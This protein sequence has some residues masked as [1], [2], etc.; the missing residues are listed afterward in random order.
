MGSAS[1]DGIVPF[2]SVTMLQRPGLVLDNN[3]PGHTGPVVFAAFGST[4]DAEPYHG[5]LVGWDARTLKQYSVFN[6]TPNGYGGSLWQSGGAPVVLPNGDI[7]ITSGNGAFDAQTT[8]PPGRMRSASPTSVWATPGSTT[9]RR[10][11]SRR[12]SPSRRTVPPACSSTASSRAPAEALER[13]VPEH[14][15]LGRQLDRAANDQAGPTPS[16]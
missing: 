1:N 3:V 6:D 14:Q 4:H 13:D 15:R 16:R 7:V 10:S 5:W 11:H 8:S 12:S 9:A 2:T